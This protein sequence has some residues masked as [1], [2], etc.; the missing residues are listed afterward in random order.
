MIAES[1]AL[2]SEEAM[3]L[4]IEPGEIVFPPEVG[5]SATCTL[6][7]SNTGRELVAFKVK[8]TAPN[9][10]F[11]KPKA[12]VILPGSSQ[13]I[14]VTLQPQTN[15]PRE[16]TDRFLVQSA[17]C[18][19]AEGLNKDEWAKLD[20]FAVNEQRLQVA[21][22]EPGTKAS[23]AAAATS[24]AASAPSSKAGPVDK[25]ISIDDLRAKYDQL[26]HYTHK[27][28]SDKATLEARST[29]AASASG[30]SLLQLIIAILVAIF[31]SRIAQ[32]NGY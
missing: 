19:T 24:Y 30:F 9:S 10:Y 6:K 14:Q 16:N 25:N 31:V 5:V 17:V 3:A 32:H 4:R 20:K 28:E 13:D 7:L 8:T 26:V 1:A 11:V 27:L 21:F 18:Q 2:F 29:K 22:R 15:D 23:S 12:G